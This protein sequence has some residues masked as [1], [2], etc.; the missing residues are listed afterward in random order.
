M[1]TSRKTISVSSA[2]KRVHNRSLDL[3]PEYQRGAV[4]S[5]KRQTLLIDSMLKG[6]DL[7]KFYMRQLSGDK[8]LYEVVD[9]VQ[10]LTSMVNFMNGDFALPKLSS[11]AGLRYKDLPE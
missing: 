6:Y 1:K 2:V 11:F 9:G 7:P 5:R 10:R 8:E 3:A 4:W